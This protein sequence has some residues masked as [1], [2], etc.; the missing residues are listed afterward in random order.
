MGAAMKICLYSPYIPDH[1]GGGEK[2]LLD[3]AQI[4]ATKHQVYLAIASLQPLTDRAKAQLLSRYQQTFALDFSQIKLI[5]SPLGT[6]ASFWTKL[7]WTKQF[8]LLYYATDGSLFFSRA[9]KNILHIQ[10]PL[11]LDKSGLLERL[12]LANWQIKN[13]NS[14][15]TK[16][17][18]EQSWKTKI[19]LVHQP[20]VQVEQF[21]LPV[22]KLTQK[23]QIILHVG[24]FFRQLHSKKQDV[25]VDIFR[26]LTT[27]YPSKTKDWQLVLI[28]AVEDEQYAQKV[29]QKAKGLN[30]KILHQLSRAE[31]IAWYQR[32]KIYWHA[33]G[34][35]VNE[36]KNPEKVEHFGISTVEAM[37]AGCAPIVISKGGQKEILGSELQDWSWLA[38]KDCVNKTMRLIREPQGLR[39]VQQQAMQRAQ[40]F[41]RQ[42][43]EQQLWA[44]VKE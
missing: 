14:Y 8:E 3:V 39:Q 43:F 24:R 25:L 23:G 27:R 32:A 10:V 13:T 20:M 36:H 5:A 17:V 1:F 29:R 15:F 42:R 22:K 40:V 35:G 11:Q 9:K 37:A 6:S 19:D 2:Y 12:K 28:G 38:K 44:M 18:I 34:F 16:Q 4:L 30:V 26:Q 21:Q 41:N 33:T 31:L 7:A